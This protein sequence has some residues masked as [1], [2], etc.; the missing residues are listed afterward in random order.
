V[1]LH[2]ELVIRRSVPAVLAALALL[3]GVLGVVYVS[4]ACESLPAFLGGVRGDSDP[5]T[6]LGVALLVGAGVLVVATLLSR[7]A[8]GPRQS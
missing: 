5:R 6:P 3:A 1:S 8:S 7:R 4:V 2:S